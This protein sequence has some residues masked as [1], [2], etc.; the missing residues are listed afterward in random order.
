MDGDGAII[1]ITGVGLGI[2]DGGKD[3]VTNMA[4]VK[5][6]TSIRSAIILGT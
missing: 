5:V 2:M 4:M 6:Q 3:V 1:G